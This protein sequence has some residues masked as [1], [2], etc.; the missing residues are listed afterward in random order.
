[1]TAGLVIDRT[2]NTIEAFTDGVGSGSPASLASVGAGI[3]TAG[4]PMT[5]GVLLD[6]VD[7]VGSFG[8]F[9]FFAAALFR[10]ADLSDA[11]WLAITA[12]IADRNA[13]LDE[14]VAFVP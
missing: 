11:E 8:S 7:V 13:S 12:L 2:A 5:V 6:A 1:M 3:S 10:R 4:L 14:Y 9:E